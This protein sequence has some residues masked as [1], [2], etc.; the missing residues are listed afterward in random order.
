MMITRKRRFY[1][2]FCLLLIFISGG[3]TSLVVARLYIS[4]LL[5]RA[6]DSDGRFFENLIAQGLTQSYS[7]EPQAENT[8]R[9]VLY[10]TVDQLRIEM[11]RNRRT[12]LPVLE[13]AVAQIREVLPQDPASLA[14]FD[15]S[16]LRT[17]LGGAPPLY[18]SFYHALNFNLAEIY[19]TQMILSVEFPHFVG[20][21]PAD[22]A[23]AKSL[24]KELLLHCLPQIRESLPP[25]KQ[26][27][28]DALG[29]DLEHLE[30][31]PRSI[32]LRH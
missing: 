20:E 16:V 24:P 19:R 27:K 28:L 15:A 14:D 9:S 3:A 30:L 17:E 5:A 10:S 1:G 2:W 22:P 4:S 23:R 11:L 21:G 12:T 18:A 29:S 6:L 13:R 31:V 7:L 26:A 25:A 32:L 8:V